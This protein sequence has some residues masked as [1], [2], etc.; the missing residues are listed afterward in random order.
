[1]REARLENGSIPLRLGAARPH[2]RLEPRSGPFCTSGPQ[3]RLRG[4]TS[5]R[6]RGV[7]TNADVG[8]LDALLPLVE[9]VLQTA[10]HLVLT[11]GAVVLLFR[12]AP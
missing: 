8:R 6:G 5:L 7:R 3:P 1:M 4:G 11:I 12:F 9:N 10:G 2:R